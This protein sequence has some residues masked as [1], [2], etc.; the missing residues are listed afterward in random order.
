MNKGV[1][2]LMNLGVAASRWGGNLSG[3][4]AQRSEM[5]GLR[6]ALTIEF[7]GEDGGAWHVRFDDG[8]TVMGKGAAADARATVRL[9]PEDYLAMLGGDLR[10]STARMT[11]RVRMSGD[12]NFAFVFGAMVENLR[13][14]QALPG[15][16]GW[17]ARAVVRRA[18]RKGN[19]AAKPRNP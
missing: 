11:G 8:K 19:Y 2:L 7:T 18:L 13:A 14:A 10:Y 16:R 9:K 5:R 17:V 1:A 3:S 12:G 15:V 6:G 4:E